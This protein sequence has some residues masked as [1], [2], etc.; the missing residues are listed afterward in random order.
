LK[1]TRRKVAKNLR[2]RETHSVVNMPAAAGYADAAFGHLPQLRARLVHA[3]LLRIKF[4]WGLSPDKSFHV[5]LLYKPP[6]MWA[7]KYTPMHTCATS[8]VPNIH[9]AG[10]S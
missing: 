8:A 10:S 1:L 9:I 3:V 7:M 5:H 4:L 6:S 2:P